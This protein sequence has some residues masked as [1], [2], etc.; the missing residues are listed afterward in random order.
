MARKQ[1]T[2]E[3]AIQSLK[4]PPKKEQ[5]QLIENAE[6]CHIPSNIT[7]TAADDLQFQNWLVESSAPKFIK[8][9]LGQQ[10]RAMAQIN[11]R[12]SGRPNPDPPRSEE[13]DS[14]DENGSNKNTSRDGSARPNPDR[15]NPGHNRDGTKERDSKDRNPEDENASNKNTSSDGFARPN[16]NSGNRQLEDEKIQ[17]E[18][19]EDEEL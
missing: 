8:N 2:A 17:D 3:S 13:R 1:G 12:R 16:L 6:V 19:L 7:P 10:L 4:D 5:K 9:H 18:E 11:R 15:P 14:E